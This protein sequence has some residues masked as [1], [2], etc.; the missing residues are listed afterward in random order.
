[1]ETKRKRQTDTAIFMPSVMIFGLFNYI[2][3]AAGVI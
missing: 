3:P 1:V 2:V